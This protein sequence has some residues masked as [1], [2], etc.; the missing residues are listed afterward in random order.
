[1]EF[2]RYDRVIGKDR[3]N[4]RYRDRLDFEVPTDRLLVR[5]LQL[6]AR[7]A[8][9]AIPRTADVCVDSVFNAGLLDHSHVIEVG[10]D[11]PSQYRFDVFSETP[12]VSAGANHACRL[13]GDYPGE[14]VKRWAMVDFPNVKREGVPLLSTVTAKLSGRA[15]RYNRLVIPMSRDGRMVSHLFV[16]FTDN[17]VQVD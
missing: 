11:A 17:L 8:G 6:S 12:T 3:I 9:E 2:N 15:V 7:R 16:A 4:V 13:L 1:M 5:A 10:A 14:A